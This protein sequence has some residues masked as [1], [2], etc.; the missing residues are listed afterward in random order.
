MRVLDAAVSAINN[1][2]SGF[3]SLDLIHRLNITDTNAIPDITWTV[4]IKN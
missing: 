4:V 1:L 3:M 2:L